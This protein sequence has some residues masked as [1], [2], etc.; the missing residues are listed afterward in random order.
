MST[1]I[2]YARKS[3]ES[4]DRQVLSIP[5]Q[6]AELQRVAAREG[7]QIAE[8]L[9]ESKSAKAPGRPVFNDLM[10]RVFRGNVQGILCW[11]MDRL[12]RNHLDTGQ[13]LQALADG[14]LERVITS[15]Q[16][17]TGDGNDRLM[18]G[19]MLG[20][21]TKFIDDLR[22]NVLRGIR[23]RLDRGWVNYR[24]P[25]GYIN[26]KAEKTIVK[27]P[28]RFDKVR[29]MWELLLTGAMRPEE[30]RRTVNE[31]GFRTRLT[32]RGGGKP[33]ARS[34]FYSMFGNPYYAGIIQW[35]NG[36]SWRGGHPPM[37]TLDEF[38]RVQEILGRP[39]RS[40]PKRHA[41]AFTGLIHCGGCGGAITAERHVKP[42]GRQYVYYRCS[43]MKSK[44]RC[45]E[46]PI[47][48]SVLEQQIVRHLG[49]LTVPDEVVSWATRHVRKVVVN[50]QARREEVHGTLEKTIAAVRR[51][52]EA[53]LSLRL[54]ELVDDSTYTEKRTALLQQRHSLEF[55]L[56]QSSR[57][58]REI[59]EFTMQTFEF[60]ARVKGAFLNGTSVQKRVVLESVGLNYTLSGKKLALEFKNPLRLLAEAASRSDWCATTDDVRTWF[61]RSTEYFSLPKL[62]VAAPLGTMPSTSQ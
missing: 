10:R 48:E 29:R 35:K 19:V 6:I 33:I 62:D 31:D 61:E 9:S 46:L 7:V 54:R 47:P 28:E 4:E 37:V 1:Y 16:V 20:M 41:F 15:D 58:P 52:E 36:E 42:N 12:A 5:S 53:L 25:L 30:I 44:E 50:E 18:G 11:K 39:G 23:A 40:R 8:V 26:D 59:G 32:K 60:A 38:D 14:K 24:P 17:Y 34:V 2:L 55:R 51:Q 49:R 13:I 57:S 22:A 56:S 43:R 45:R 27:D 3:T 21:A